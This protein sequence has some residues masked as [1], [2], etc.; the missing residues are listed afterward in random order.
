MF[1]L[2][3]K[4]IAFQKKEIFS[5]K[6]NFSMKNLIIRCYEEEKSSFS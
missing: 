6:G 4:I 3:I 2:S 5:K 1:I